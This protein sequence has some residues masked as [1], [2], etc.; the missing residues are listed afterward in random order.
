M[1]FFSSLSRSQGAL[2][3]DAK[4]IMADHAAMNLATARA[5][6]LGAIGAVLPTVAA[7]TA[8]KEPAPAV[9]TAD[10][11]ASAS[12]TPSVPGSVSVVATEVSPPASVLSAPVVQPYPMNMPSCP[13][14]AFCVA[15]PAKLDAK[16]AAAA[17]FGKCAGT[18]IH[19]DDAD[20]GPGRARMGSFSADRTKA[21]RTK[22]ASACC[23]TWVVPCPGGRVFRDAT[24]MPS[25]ARVVAREDWVAQVGDLSVASLSV[26]ERALLAAHWMREA[27]FE[28]ASIASF[29]QLT[30]DL[31]SVAA[32][33][34]LLEA[35][36]RA[37]LDEIEHARITFAL[38]AAYGGAAVG[39][40]S[41]A[42]M[43]G[44]CR[45]LSALAKRTF[46]DACVGESVASA[47]LAEDA[48]EATDPVL[49]N[50]LA[51]MSADEER[52]AE[53][54]WKIVAW[55]L[56]VGDESVAHALAEAQG[57]VIDELV[58]GVPGEHGELRASVLREVVVPCSAAMLAGAG[59]MVNAVEVDGR[60][61]GA[62]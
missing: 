50:L 39:P 60:A 62:G 30:L 45:T 26:E 12:T 51:G 29:A 8:C 7:V 41:L 24:G 14:G 31:L 36:Q 1:R 21:E 47:S 33:P 61:R 48:R 34:E 53:L 35:T 23:Y 46:L 54:A 16:R 59:V 6:Y 40:A 38:A 2:E 4:R 55:A 42:A 58:A 32:P 44:S 49:A 3:G 17:P 15:E 43:P 37:T 52:H 57:E 11:P 27:A 5:R 22:T 28:H 25:V 56:S 19:P 10:G 9:V 18:T 13:S 20:A